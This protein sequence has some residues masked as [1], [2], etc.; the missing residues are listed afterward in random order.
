MRKAPLKGFVSQGALTVQLRAS[1]DPLETRKLQCFRYQ[2]C[3]ATPELPPESQFSSKITTIAKPTLIS[4]ITAPNADPTAD[5]VLVGIERNPV[6]VAS[7]SVH[8]DRDASF[9]SETFFCSFKV[10]GRGVMVVR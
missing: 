5:H 7:N 6:F 9:P 4:N 2:T 10:P 3:T 1:K 8:N